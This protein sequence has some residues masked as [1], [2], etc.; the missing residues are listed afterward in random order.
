MEM[1]MRGLG[2]LGLMY[3]AITVFG[4]LCRY[5][6]GLL[7]EWIGQRII[8]DMRADVFRKAIQLSLPF[9]DRN[10]VGRL[11][12]RVTSDVDALQRFVTDGVVG[13]LAD[14]FML[15]GVL[16]F[17]VYLSPPPCLRDPGHLARATAFSG[18]R[19]PAPAAGAPRD[20]G[21]DL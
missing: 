4:F 18:G 11:M 14:L 2:Q 12:T 3:L 1:R 6:Q 21:A 15:L 17:M 8:C 7:T 5:G 9:F 16:G 20:P 10:P 19:Q 13:T